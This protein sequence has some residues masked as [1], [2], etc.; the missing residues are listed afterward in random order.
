[1]GG[2]NLLHYDALLRGVQLT[3]IE[4]F[5]VPHVRTAL[6][7]LLPSLALV[8]GDGAALVPALVRNLTTRQPAARVGVLLDGP[9]GRTAAEVGAAVAANATLVVLDDQASSTEQPTTAPRA[10]SIQRSRMCVLCVARRAQVY[11]GPW[12]GGHGLRFFTTSALWQSA[13]PMSREAALVS[14][15]LSRRLYFRTNDNA[16]A[17]ILLG[18]R[19]RPPRGGAEVIT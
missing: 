4:R 8:D 5:P 1:M 19:W 14:D 13:L 17:T 11:V 16:A 12:E 3:S 7:R 6:H 9:K 10:R 18:E 15:A 2:L